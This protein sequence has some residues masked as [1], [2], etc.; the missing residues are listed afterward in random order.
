MHNTQVDL[1]GL[2]RNAR[3]SDFS[4]L[5]SIYLHRWLCWFINPEKVKKDI[6]QNLAWRCS[7]SISYYVTEFMAFKV[8]VMVL[9][10]FLLAFGLSASQTSA[11]IKGPNLLATSSPPFLTFCKWVCN[12][13]LWIWTFAAIVSWLS[14]NSFSFWNGNSMCLS[15]RCLLVIYDQLNLTEVFA[16]N[17]L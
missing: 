7:I 17:L 1:L 11:I 9:Q 15:L 6:T 5:P 3:W 4:W 10:P 2:L 13:F 8:R 16:H 12:Q 14:L